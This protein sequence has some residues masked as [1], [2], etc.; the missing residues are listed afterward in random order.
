MTSNKFW[1][2]VHGGS[3]HFPIA[4]LIGSVLFDL[5][6]Y[7]SPQAKISRDLHV[8][9]FYALILGALGSFAAVASGL[10]LTNW[11]TL[12]SGTLLKHHE[13]VWPAFGLI[14]GMAVWRL[15]VGEKASRPAFGVY[16]GVAVVAM[17]LMAAAGYWGGELR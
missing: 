11:S 4:L 8:A 13:F 15:L 6:G 16:L 10:L 5:I 12:G 9:S 7:F 17:I 3:T 1:T 2:I 14:V